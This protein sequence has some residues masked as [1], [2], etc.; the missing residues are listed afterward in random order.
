MLS[1]ICT[2]D[3][4]FCRNIMHGRGAVEF[5]FCLAPNQHGY[6]ILARSYELYPQ[7]AELNNLESSPFHR[8][9]SK[10]GFMGVSRLIYAIY[11]SQKASLHNF[12]ESRRKQYNPEGWTNKGQR[13]ILCLLQDDAKHILHLVELRSRLQKVLC[14]N[15]FGLGSAQA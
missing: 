4:E 11:I 14:K 15:W 13:M 3:F 9:Y 5:M 2:R 10:S 7:V 6:S 8:E 12:L 1:L